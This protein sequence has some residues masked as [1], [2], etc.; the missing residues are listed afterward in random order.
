MPKKYHFLLD[1]MGG[2]EEYEKAAAA[3]YAKLHGVSVQRV[4]AQALREFLVLHGHEL[5]V[6]KAQAE[7]LRSLGS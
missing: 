2:M 4:I 7:Q 1:R 6:A 5:Q 3:A